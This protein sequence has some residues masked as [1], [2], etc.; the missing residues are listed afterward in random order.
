MPANRR[1]TPLFRSAG[2][3]PAHLSERA[4]LAMPVPAN[5]RTRIY[6][7]TLSGLYAEVTPTGHRSWG[8]ARRAPDGGQVRMRIGP[9]GA[10]TEVDARNIAHDW[11]A[12]I[13]RGER[14][15]Q[16]MQ[17]ARR[18]EAQRREEQR[19]KSITV[20]HAW[21]SFDNMQDGRYRPKSTA[22]ATSLWA[23]HLS[24]LCDRPIADVTVADCVALHAE[25]GRLVGQPTANRMRSLGC[26][27]WR[28]A[29]LH[30]GQQGNPWREVP[31]F[32]ESP[33]TRV[34]TMDEVRRLLMSLN[35]LEPRIAALFR[36][37]FL[38]GARRGSVQ[39]MS[40]SDIDLE[41][42]VWTIPASVSKSGRAVVLPLSP[43]A[44]A[45]LRE[46]RQ[47]V[48]ADCDWVF[49]SR[50]RDGYVG[51]VRKA[52]MKVCTAADISNAHLHDIRR[53]YATVL[54]T[55]GVPLL[56]I[57]RLLGHANTRTTEAVYAVL[58]IDALRAPCVQASQLLCMDGGTPLEITQASRD[59]PEDCNSIP[60]T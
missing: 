7:G 15:D 5:G 43:A 21:D 48:S 10:I 32:R 45:V 46:R 55:A 2:A 31:L 56:A 14:P 3:H 16:D 33:R 28:H 36:M 26:A 53:S 20:G 17:A 40:W 52:W 12:R 11:N 29:T 19:L 49:A 37:L 6:D 39:S 57:S 60:L 38:T 54:A 22:S 8:F 42:A 51:D 35:V 18:R 9:V 4:A 44:V 13:A 24:A 27:I 25:V 34:L 41:R 47:Y 59:C 50:W 23:C 58:G 30:L 1:P